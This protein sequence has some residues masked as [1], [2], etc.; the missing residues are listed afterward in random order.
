MEED[1]FND[2]REQAIKLFHAQPAKAKE[3]IGLD[4]IFVSLA[5]AD[6]VQEK[7]ASGGKGT[8]KNEFRLAR[9]DQAPDWFHETVK[10]MREAGEKG[11]TIQRFLLV[12]KRFPI[13]RMDRVNVGR[14]L[15]EE[16]YVPRRSAGQVL[17]DL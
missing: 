4:A 12:A 10:K 15:R 16:G 2:M 7:V 8:A 9:D 13:K 6:A 3:K 17:W 5:L 11:V 1:S 14:W